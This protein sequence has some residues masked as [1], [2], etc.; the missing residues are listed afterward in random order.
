MLDT[1][2]LEIPIE[3]R[4]IIDQSKFSPPA[5]MIEVLQGFFR[6]TNNPKAIDRKSGIYKPRLTLIKRGVMLLLKIEFSAPKLIFNNNLDE[7]E[8][9]DFN[10]LVEK[11]LFYSP[12]IVIEE[13]P[14]F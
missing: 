1:I 13:I 11:S 2:I 5:R 3:F 10:S 8:E 9:S 14:I 6:C 7:L 4:A 12:K